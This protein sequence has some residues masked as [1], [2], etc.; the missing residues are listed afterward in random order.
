MALIFFVRHTLMSSEKQFPS[1]SVPFVRRKIFISLIQCL[2]GN[3][4]LTVFI[5]ATI[6]SRNNNKKKPLPHM[7]GYWSCNET[8][9]EMLSSVIRIPLFIEIKTT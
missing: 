7:A 4:Q 3:W 1:L 9:I 6:K 2:F 5:F 8:I